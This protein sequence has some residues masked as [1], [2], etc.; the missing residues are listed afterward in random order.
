MELYN[1]K[2]RNE[3]V[4][5]AQAIKQGLGRQQGL[6]FPMTLPEFALTEDRRVA[7]NGFRRTQRAHPV[8]L[9]R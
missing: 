1:I 4:S 2:E 9:Y 7:G 5:F 8:G 6:F 3:Q